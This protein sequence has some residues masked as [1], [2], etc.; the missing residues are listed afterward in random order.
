MCEELPLYASYG[1]KH[2]NIWLDNVTYS[3]NSHCEK[4]SVIKFMVDPK[5][6]TVTQIAISG[7]ELYLSQYLTLALN[8]SM[9]FVKVT[10]FSKEQ[11]TGFYFDLPGDVIVDASHPF[12]A[13]NPM[14]GTIRPIQSPIFVVA[15]FGM[16]S[17]KKLK[18]LQM[19]DVIHIFQIE[20]RKLIN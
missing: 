15:S 10:W 20:A 12:S 17:V 3:Q 16:I 4:E 14:S 19:S 1:Y 13:Y 9:K 8:A 5:P 7:I 6:K 2:A 11:V 18:S